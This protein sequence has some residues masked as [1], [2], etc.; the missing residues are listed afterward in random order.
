[1]AIPSLSLSSGLLSSLSSGRNTLFDLQR[2]LATG[3][4]SE[5][6]GGLS[7]GSRITVLSL[8]AEI[9]STNAFQTNIRDV[10]LRLDVVQQTLSRFTGI[11]ADT[12]AGA[13]ASPFDLI[14]GQH[15][16]FQR[17][18]G[19]YFDE[20]LSLL[21]SNVNGSYLFAGRKSDAPPVQPTNLILNG[22]GTRAGLI[23]LMNERTAADKGAAG[24]G[25]LAISAP[26]PDTVR[27]SEEA[28][29]LPFGFKLAGATG[30]LNNVTIT[31]PAGAP[32]D[33][34]IQFGTPLPAPGQTINILLNLPDGSQETMQFKASSTTPLKPREFAIGADAATTAA[35]FQAA[36]QTELARQA[37]TTLA[38]ASAVV[39]SG[40]FFSGSP[41]NPPQRVSGPPFDTATAMVA[42]TAAN[43]VVWYQ[44]DDSAV[45]AR[46]GA[47]ARIDDQLVV[48]HGTRADEEA[49]RHT[50]QYLG[51]VSATVYS[52]SDPNAADRYEALNLRAVRALSFPASVQSF[53]DITTELA[54]VQSTLES[55]SERHKTANI[56]SEK[57]ISERE[58]ADIQEVGAAILTLRTRLD[59]SMATTSIIAKLS[60]VNFI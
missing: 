52:S 13:V 12:K 2:Q 24:L 51:A 25:R 42:G 21:N 20:M 39:A 1:M 60:L 26:A 35:S 56:L 53:Q 33:L 16:A 22:D 8:R 41:T 6:Y 5:T 31:G 14:D 18:T 27:L 17:N 55:T 29:G 34:D 4:L 45:P 37:D 19:A 47:L 50:L 38:A 36:L 30:N 32:P 57:L 11:A 46:Q 43:T 49:M 28:I 44:G 7:S 48:A 59:A 40:D 54:T 10:N 15:T 58:D 9:S 23:Q 3:K